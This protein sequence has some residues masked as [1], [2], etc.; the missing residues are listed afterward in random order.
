M[1]L[2]IVGAVFVLRLAFLKISKKNEAAILANGGVEYGV[3]NTK[4]LT[5]AHIMFYLGCFIEA[6]LRRT[7]LD[8]ISLLGLG[9]LF[10]A[11]IMLVVV[12]RLL[13]DIWTVKL[14]IA[15]NHQ[16]N[17]HWL[18]RVVKHPNYFLNI[19]PEL[20]GLSLLCHAWYTLLFVGPLYAV[21]LG[22]R[23]K[24]ENHLIVS[25]IL[26]NSEKSR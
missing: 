26:P 18:F 10:F 22:N 5:I 19:A 2:M 1:I 9:L 7:A 20:I 11:F 15:N 13:S 17:D 16:F 25:Q 4:R 6:Y 14:M 3:E 12:V 24:E 21:I 23:I 8:S